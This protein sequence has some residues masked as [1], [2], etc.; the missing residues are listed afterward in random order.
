VQYYL[1][2][3]NI[4]RLWQLHRV[5]GLSLI[6]T[7]ANKFRTTAGQIRRKYQKAVATLHGTQKVLEVVVERG[8]NKKPL[9]ARFGGIE[10]RWQKCAILDDLPKELFSVRSDVVQRLLAQKC[11]LCA[12]EEGPFQVLH[13]C[14]LADLDRRIGAQNRSGSSGWPQAW[15][16]W[17][18]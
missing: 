11:E 2:A 9:R 10:L 16:G 15:V 18:T 6:K 8:G 13:V 7:L 1:L 5:M 3:V 17:A 12:S 14:K 4:H